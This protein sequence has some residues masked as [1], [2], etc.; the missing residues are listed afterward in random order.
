MRSPP[1]DPFERSEGVSELEMKSFGAFC[2]SGEA[3][4]TVNSVKM[5]SDKLRIE[6]CRSIA[7]FLPNTLFFTPRLDLSLR[8]LADTPSVP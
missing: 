8:V 3:I 4:L 5:T 6:L 7:R 1:P 2:G